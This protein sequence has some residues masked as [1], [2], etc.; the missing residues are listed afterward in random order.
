MGSGLDE[1]IYW[2]FARRS[3][4]YLLHN[5]TPHKR[6]TLSSLSCILAPEFFLVTPSLV[7]FCLQQYL[8]ICFLQSSLALSC[9]AQPW[10]T[11]TVLVL[12]STG[13]SPVLYCLLADES[14]LQA[15][16]NPLKLAPGVPSRG[17]SVEQFIFLAVMQTS[18][19]LLREQRFT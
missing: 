9:T 11:N 7:V 19:S 8:S 18:L 15:F 10:Q 12:Y 14:S 16:S 3:Y 5:L 17:H 2:T 4:N 6:K 1:A 13:F